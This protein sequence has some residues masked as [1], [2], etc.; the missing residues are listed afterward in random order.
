MYVSGA[1]QLELAAG[2]NF[3]LHKACSHRAQ[4]SHVRH[5]SQTGFLGWGSGRLR[6]PGWHRGRNHCEQTQR[7]RA[8]LF[9]LECGSSCLRYSSISIESG[10]VDTWASTKR[11]AHRQSPFSKVGFIDSLTCCHSAWYP[12][13]GQ[14]C[15]EIEGAD[16]SQAC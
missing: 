4:S 2:G 15:T 13:G 10:E 1:R 14:S 12:P 6:Q 5:E 9:H 7:L 3:E 11:G 8:H 16:V